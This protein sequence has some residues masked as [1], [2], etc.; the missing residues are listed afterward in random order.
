M[1]DY[2]GARE[3][4]KR[5]GRPGGELSEQTLL[6]LAEL[7]RYREGCRGERLFLAVRADGGKRGSRPLWRAY[8]SSMLQ[9]TTG[10]S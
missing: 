4:L 5:M 6:V 7:Y 10:A 9:L 3:L 2:S 8:P 1:R